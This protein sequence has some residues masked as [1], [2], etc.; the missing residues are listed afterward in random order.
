MSLSLSPRK[1][2]NPNST[3]SPLTFLT[4]PPINGDINVPP[5]ADA[6]ACFALVSNILSSSTYPKA[7]AKPD[8]T[9]PY[10]AI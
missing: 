9:K 10:L 5:T 4:A 6:A 8:V 7:P 1:P 3:F 2:G